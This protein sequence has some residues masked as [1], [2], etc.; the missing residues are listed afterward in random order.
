MWSPDTHAIVL[1][2]IF[3][4]FFP[5]TEVWFLFANMGRTT[6]VVA[7]PNDQSP[8][9]DTLNIVSKKQQKTKEKRVKG[10]GCT[11]RLH[12]CCFHDFYFFINDCHKKRR[13][14]NKN[15][16][17]LLLLLSTLSFVCSWEVSIQYISIVRFISFIWDSNRKRLRCVH[18]KI[19]GRMKVMT[20]SSMMV[21]M[22]LNRMTQ[23]RKLMPVSMKTWLI[24]TV[25][26]RL[27]RLE[28]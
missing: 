13:N 22:L 25:L 8:K 9:V 23:M 16:L 2:G 10:S 3:T 26:N 24:E 19:W 17:T 7:K 27:S 15:L 18:C 4:V 21:R 14:S 1:H 20:M 11:D 12:C 5:F 6:T 28:A